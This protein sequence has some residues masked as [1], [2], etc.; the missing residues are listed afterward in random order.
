MIVICPKCSK[1][2]MLDNA[3]LPP[4]GRQVRCIS[5]EEVWRQIPN[6][7]S[8][9]NPPPFLGI[10]SSE[11]TIEIR[12]VPQKRSFLLGSIIILAFILCLISGLIFARNTIVAFW[13]KSEQIYNL[14]GLQVSLPGAGL[15]ISNL[16]SHTIQ[17]GPIEMIIVTGDVLNT[18][19]KVRPIPPL[20]IFISKDNYKEPIL[21]HW[22]H[23]LSENALLPGEHIHFETTA[24]PKVKGGEYV[25]VEP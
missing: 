12:R 10:P 20:K 1:R 5:C 4:E 13:P 24:R 8:L 2:Y 21:D 18:S 6:P 11:E 9:I 3:L 17:D 25:T 7:P 15:L 22:D 14:M 23:R 16:A 19:D